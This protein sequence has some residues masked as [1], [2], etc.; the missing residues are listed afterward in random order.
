VVT[1]LFLTSVYKVG[2]KSEPLVQCN[3]MY[4]RYHFFRPPSIAA[5]RWRFGLVVAREQVNVFITHHRKL[6]SIATLLQLLSVGQRHSSS[7]RP[8]LIPLLTNTL[9]GPSASEVTT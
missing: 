5:A 3:V 6:F 9:P 7:P 8:S 2:Q 1:C 4:E